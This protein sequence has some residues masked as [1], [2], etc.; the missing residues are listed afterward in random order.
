VYKRIEVSGVMSP[1]P[2]VEEWRL[3]VTFGPDERLK[4]FKWRWN[5]PKFKPLDARQREAWERVAPGMPKAQVARLLGRPA[6]IVIQCDARG[7]RDEWSYDVSEVSEGFYP[8][9]VFDRKG[10]V[11]RTSVKVPLGQHAA[12]S[13]TRE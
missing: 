13:A 1:P 6:D 12:E 11:A 7:Y 9:V 3:T 2:E 10:D 4:R 5:A 8:Y